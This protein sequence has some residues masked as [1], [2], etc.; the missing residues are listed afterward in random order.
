MKSSR[1]FWQHLVLWVGVIVALSLI[2]RVVP[3]YGT[4]WLGLRRY[5]TPYTAALL[6]RISAG[7]AVAALPA[8]MAA[9]RH[10][11][12]WDRIAQVNLLRFAIAPLAAA[13]AVFV[14]VGF[15]APFAARSDDPSPMPR[16][17]AFES[18]YSFNELLPAS[19]RFREQAHLGAR[20]GDPYRYNPMEKAK[21]DRLKGRFYFVTM[22][23]VAPLLLAWIGVLVRLW[24]SLLPKQERAL[25]DWLTALVLLLSIQVTVSG[26]TGWFDAR[27]GASPMMVAGTG[28]GLL[29]VPGLVLIALA[30]TTA[31]ARRTFR[32]AAA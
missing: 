2:A 31:V 22:W 27:Y 21:A 6:E 9:S 7:I 11:L 3:G 10:V 13:L 16:L 12:S 28:R 1:V 8:G 32:P 17:G 25:A 20:R 14:L 30:W 15:V 24:S 29:I 19:A 26:A 4:T 23:S 5:G 18:Y